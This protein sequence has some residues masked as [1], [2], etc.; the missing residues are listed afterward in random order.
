MA[1]QKRKQKYPNPDKAEANKF[2]KIAKENFEAMIPTLFRIVF[3]M[4]V[5]RME[6]PP[7]IRIQTTREVEPDWMKIIFNDE[8][9][10]GCLF[11]LEFDTGD[12]KW[13]DA[14]ALNY[15][16]VAHL[17]YRL[18]VDFRLVYFSQGKPKNISGKVAFCK[19]NF[20]YPVYCFEDYGYEPFINSEA[21]EDVIA[22]I[23]AN[24]EGKSPEEI[25]GIIMRRL[26]ELKGNTK[27]L[28]KFI[29]QLK[30]LSMLRNL[31]PI[32]EQNIE[33]MITIPEDWIRQMKEDKL[34]W[35]IQNEIDKDKAVEKGMEKGVEKGIKKGIEKGKEEEKYIASRNMLKLNFTHETIAGILDVATA[36]VA[37]VQLQMQK[38]PEIIAALK[39][40]NPNL[41]AIA[42][43]L[44]VSPMLIAA[45][46]KDL[47]KQAS[48]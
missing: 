21:P 19:L 24:F 38:E 20:E 32:I 29:H 31:Q 27:E 6:N 4:K 11:V 2:D 41:A 47:D 16:S 9:P 25:I 35:I 48:K 43:R 1:K 26:V 34:F 13:T 10:E 18:P 44:K 45:V 36:Y 30:I 5:H 42:K 17:E 22:A 40:V 37:K 23:L 33:K 14:R 46:K 8:Y 12:G 15:T 3:R 7:K 39:K 28:W